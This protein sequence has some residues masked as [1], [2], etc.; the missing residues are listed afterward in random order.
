MKFLLA[1]K[2]CTREDR[3]SNQEIREELN[4]FAVQDKIT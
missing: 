1:L 2:V 4:I 3:T